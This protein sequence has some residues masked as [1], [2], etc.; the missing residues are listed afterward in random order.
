MPND[1]VSN[2]WREE[3]VVPGEYRMK[4]AMIGRTRNGSVL[5]SVAT[6]HSTTTSMTPHRIAIKP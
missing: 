4:S 6:C 2:D 3:E 1:R 5:A